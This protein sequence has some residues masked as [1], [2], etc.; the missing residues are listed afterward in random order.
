MRCRI[1]ISAH[2]AIRRADELSTHGAKMAY[3]FET[4]FPTDDATG[5][6]TMI[7]GGT[8]ASHPHTAAG[9]LLG[10]AG[11]LI[12]QVTHDAAA[13]TLA[14]AAT[15]LNADQR[16]AAEQLHTAIVGACIDAEL[17]V[18]VSESVGK[19]GDGTL[20]KNLLHLLVTYGPSLWP[21]IQGFIP[22]A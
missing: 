2:R 4:S 19:I 7:I 5:L 9:H 10:V 6:G 16:F 1:L 15:V 3:V 18:P 12:G 21:I 20:L 13:T 22:K 8:V 14:E 11:Y 17:S